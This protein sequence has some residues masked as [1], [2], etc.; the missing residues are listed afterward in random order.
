MKFTPTI[1]VSV[2]MYHILEPDEITLVKNALKKTIPL[3][4]EI[5]KKYETKLLVLYTHATLSIDTVYR[6][7]KLIRKLKLPNNSL[8]V[9]LDSGGGDMNSAFKIVKMLK[10]H[11]KHTR[12]IVPF[13]AKSA[14]SFIALGTDEL[15]MCKSAELGPVDPQV[16]D[17]QSNF[18]VPAHSIKEAIDFIERNK[19]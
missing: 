1:P 9:L 4:N 3:I 8:T 13:F 5:E 7:N 14:A 18:F 12:T 11:A 10:N 19:G 17:I 6:V 15:V 16:K 2:I